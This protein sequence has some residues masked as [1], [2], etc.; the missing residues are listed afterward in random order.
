MQHHAKTLAALTLG[1]ATLA[2]NAQAVRTE[3]NMSLELATKIAAATV[4]ACTAD[5]FNVTATVVD[6]A[7]TVRA[8]YRADNAGPHTLGA[9]QA[10][11]FTSA[12]G[13][14]TSLAMME[15]AQKNPAGANVAMIP[16]FLLLGGGVP[17]KV[18]DEVIGAVGVG[19]APG[20]HLDEK[21]ALAGIAAV[22]EL[23]K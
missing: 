1:F 11:A 19:G 17:V 21:C 18:G 9:S 23:L 13:K 20:G 14:N 4:A 12:S 15:N 16:G 3:K 8:V 7:G 22:Q 2:V 6:R 10:K 5:R